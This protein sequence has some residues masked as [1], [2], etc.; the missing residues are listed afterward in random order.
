ML[1]QL[2][3]PAVFFEAQILIRHFSQQLPGLYRIARANVGLFEKAVGRCRQNAL[4]GAFDPGP[5]R[6]MI[7]D[8][9]E[10]QG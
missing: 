1:G 10:Q 9:N 4:L 7:G 3:L 8:W 5:C 6:N 2:G